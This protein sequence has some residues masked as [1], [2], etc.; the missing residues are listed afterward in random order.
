MPSPVPPAP[1]QES[2]PQAAG[3]GHLRLE[4]GVAERAAARCDE[5]ADRVLAHRA[6]LA[7]L[8]PLQCGT[9][10]TGTTLGDQLDRKLHGSDSS[11]DQVL[12][13]QARTLGE[14]AEAFRAAG[15]A[16]QAQDEAAAGGITTC[17]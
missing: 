10:T 17:G 7:G 2:L 9:S 13:E 8:G 11:V 12:A 6:R 4:P 15:R 14:V 16:A 1:A 3:S 5:L